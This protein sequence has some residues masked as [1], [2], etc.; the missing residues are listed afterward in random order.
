V[1]DGILTFILEILL[2]LY[3]IHTKGLVHCDLHSGNMVMT[4]TKLSDGEWNPHISQIIDFGL[5]KPHGIWINKKGNI[6]CNRI[7]NILGELELDNDVS[8]HISEQCW[9]DPNTRPPEVNFDQESVI[10]GKGDIYSLGF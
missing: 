5:T 3:H 4:R 8:K 10:T 6:Q 9:G 1:F 2:G 7:G